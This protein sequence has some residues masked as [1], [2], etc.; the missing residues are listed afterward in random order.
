MP[1]SVARKSYGGRLRRVNQH[2]VPTD[3]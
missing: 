3:K 1:L 2:D